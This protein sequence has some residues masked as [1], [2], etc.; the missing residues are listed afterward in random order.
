MQMN[1]PSLNKELKNRN[2]GLNQN[3]SVNRQSISLEGN[4][5]EE[6]FTKK[7]TLKSLTDKIEFKY[8]NMILRS[9]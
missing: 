6:T 4:K 2:I 1:A 3:I 9:S 7:R 5:R 8:K